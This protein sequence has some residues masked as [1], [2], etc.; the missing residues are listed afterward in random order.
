M[1]KPTLLTLLYACALTGCQH[2]P[3]KAY[4]GVVRP[5]KSGVDVYEAGT[6]PPRPYKVIQSFSDRGDV[7]EE[8]D[9][10]RDFVRDAQ[11]MGADGIIFKGTGEGGYNWGL[12]GG[13]KE[14]S[15]SAIAIV[16]TDQPQTAKP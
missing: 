10:H 9:K 12:G 2:A 6:V 1:K 14:V 8:A 7:G 3:L 15:F 11:R 5:P 13:K 4:D 16:Y